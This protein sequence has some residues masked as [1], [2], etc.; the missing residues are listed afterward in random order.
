MAGPGE[1]ATCARSPS[2]RLV[3]PGRV[4]TGLSRKGHHGQSSASEA[5][6]LQKQPLL[7]PRRAAARTRPH[8]GIG[9][10]FTVEAARFR[11][12]GRRRRLGSVWEH[13]QRAGHGD[14]ALLA[15][16]EPGSGHPP[17][18]LR[19]TGWASV[20]GGCRAPSGAGPLRPSDAK[21]GRG[22]GWGFSFSGHWAGSGP[23][24]VGSGSWTRALP[25]RLSRR[26]G[27]G[28]SVF[29]GQSQPLSG[30][31]GHSGSWL[32]PSPGRH[33]APWP[34]E[35]C[36]VD[37]AGRPAGMTRGQRQW[38]TSSEPRA[39]YGGR[40]LDVLPSGQ[41]RDGPLLTPLSPLPRP[42]KVQG[43]AAHLATRA[44]FPGRGFALG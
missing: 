17:G 40:V 15:R 14:P 36:P 32:L 24:L 29:R 22:R 39:S 38:G 33:P 2:G 44:P 11:L 19:G 42:P 43:P 25:G 31:H 26:Q 18:T 30:P 27:R 5:K 20:A 13:S 34:A 7:L 10:A 6:C 35:P 21:G 41:V 4:R 1:M 12:W 37:P 3:G 28:G 8:S 23:G 16:L 9:L